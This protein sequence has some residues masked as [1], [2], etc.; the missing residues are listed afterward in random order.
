MSGY[1]AEPALHRVA[2]RDATLATA[3][4]VAAVWAGSRAG[5]DLDPALLGYLGATIVATFALT[6]R[7]SAFWRRLPSAFY[8]RALLT[9]LRDPWRARTVF[10]AAAIDLG[11]QR[12]IAARSRTRWLA[13]LAL[14]LGTLTSFAITVPLVFGWIHFAA[15]GQDHYRPVVLGIVLG[16]FALDGGAAWLAFHAL[17]LAGGA[18]AFGATYFLTARLRRRAL[19]GVTDPGHVL[20]LALLLFVAL[21]GLALPASRNHA[22]LFPAVSLL[23]EAAVVVLLV[24]LPFSKLAH[25]L[26]RPLQ[27]G[28]RVV[29]ASTEW[30]ACG[31]CGA[32]LA[33][34][35]QVAAVQALLAARGARLAGHLQQCPPCRRRSTAAA[36]ARLLGARFHP[37]LVDTS[38]QARVPDARPYTFG[39]VA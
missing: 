34:S 7:V 20:P 12:F 10:H 18:V 39:K 24:G 23:H 8:G 30:S 35:V 22:E 33:P 9:A 17:A 16:R 5:R 26:I 11:T 15:D 6:W 36:Q 13:H 25:V 14:S 28:A 1:G 27:L 29:R 4:V 32:R 38:P 2:L 37:D 3:L 21:S 19:P 31:M